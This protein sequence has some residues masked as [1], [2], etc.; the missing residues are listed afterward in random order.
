MQDRE[1]E[2]RAGMNVRNTEPLAK[3]RR[4]GQ[5]ARRHPAAAEPRHGKVAKIG[6]YS[7]PR[8][9]GYGLAGTRKDRL[10]QG[11]T[12]RRIVARH[13]AERHPVDGTVVLQRLFE[14]RAGER[15]CSAGPRTDQQPGR[16]GHRVEPVDAADEGPIVGEVEI[17]DAVTDAGFRHRIGLALKRPGDVDEN[18]ERMPREHAVE[19]VL[20]IQHEPGDAELGREGLD[21]RPI[22][23]T[24]RQLDPG[25]AGEQPT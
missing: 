15:R 21:L 17:V 12:A 7:T 1:F 24:G 8:L 22:A 18:V 25:I 16:L 2:P 6:P 19:V 14:D 4:L 5:I 9:I 10:H 20:P 11:T 13:D 23:R 3:Q